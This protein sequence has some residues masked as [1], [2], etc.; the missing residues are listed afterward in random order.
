MLMSMVGAKASAHD[1][2]V[3]NA[4]GVTIYYVW[5]SD[6]TELAVSYR[7]SYNYAY[8]NEYSGN[9]VIP[10]SVTYGGKEYSVTSIGE[11]AFWYCS[12]LTSVT[13]SNS[14]TY[15]GS[16][17]F[18]NCSGLTSVEIPNS[19]T[20]IGSYP[21]YGCS[22]LTSVTLHCKEVGN[23][24]SGLKSVKDVVFGDEVT[25]IGNSA[26]SDC[27]GLESVTMSNGVVTI[28][29]SAFSGTALSSIL[30]PYS[31]NSIGANAFSGCNQLQQVIVKDL[32]AWCKIGFGN[33]TSNPLKMAGH[34]FS[35]ETTEITELTIPESITKI[36]NYAF[37]GWSA[38]K[39]V[40]AC[41]Q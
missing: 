18:E 6:K 25:A 24:F 4:D 23:W 37:N 10:S 30:I 3:K 15:I 14:V 21:F 9:V 7:G 13:I 32:E 19:V 1:I 29:S 20:S 27:I 11:K 38:L 36:G 22:G 41:S 17:A 26:F 31:I 28:G 35:D 2:E 33:D 5:N 8:S 12:G 40:L 34:L 39:N 16:Q